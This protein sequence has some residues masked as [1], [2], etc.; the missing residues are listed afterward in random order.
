MLTGNNHLSAVLLPFFLVFYFFL[1]LR[2]RVDRT[3]ARR[4][5]TQ[6]KRNITCCCCLRGPSLYSFLFLARLLHRYSFVS[7]GYILS[8]FFLYYSTRSNFFFF[9]SL[10]S[11][12]KF[13]V[14]YFFAGSMR[15]HQV[16]C[17]MIRR[18]RSAMIR[19]IPTKK[20]KSN[21]K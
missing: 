18:N 12:I 7:R 16:R 11:L 9:F 19:H 2:R 14:F 10:T 4:G 5:N 20:E 17:T 15:L 3:V 8:L 13:K 1:Y 21:L 6:A